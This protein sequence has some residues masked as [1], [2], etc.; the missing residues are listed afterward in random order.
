MPDIVAALKL[1]FTDADIAFVKAAPS[2]GG[3]D[4]LSIKW[5]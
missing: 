1:V 5:S 4:V 2:S 3:K